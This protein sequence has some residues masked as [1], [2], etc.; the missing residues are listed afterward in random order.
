MEV[1]KL[2]LYRYNHEI[3]LSSL[4]MTGVSSQLSLSL[5]PGF[6]WAF[7]LGSHW[8]DL[9]AHPRTQMMLFLLSGLSLLSPSSLLLFDAA[10]SPL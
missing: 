4:D 6:I 3:A 7:F 5:S 8:E 1:G 9:I 2:W 10:V